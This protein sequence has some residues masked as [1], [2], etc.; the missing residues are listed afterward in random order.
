MLIV[1]DLDGTL[2]DSSHRYRNKPCG[3]IDLEYWFANATPENIAKDKLK[4]L[5]NKFRRHAME[6]SADVI[7]C[8]ARTMSDADYDFLE[9]HGLHI[10]PCLSREPGDN[11]SDADIKEELID[12]YLDLFH[13]KCI[14]DTRVIVYEDNLS[15]IDRLRSRGAICS[16]EI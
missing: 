8:T 3:S 14:D 15:V 7:I 9:E 5:V 13:H 4:P 12:A 6:S 16:L 2:I 10:V 1:Y 11:R